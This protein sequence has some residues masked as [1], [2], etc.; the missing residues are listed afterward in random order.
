MDLTREPNALVF[1]QLAQLEERNLAD[2]CMCTNQATVDMDSVFDT[3][4]DRCV[5]E[6]LVG[7]DAVNFRGENVTSVE[8]CVADQDLTQAEPSVTTKGN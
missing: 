2:W 7:S 1:S 5:V 6:P 8:S 4:R 3:T